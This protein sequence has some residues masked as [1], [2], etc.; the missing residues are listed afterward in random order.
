VTPD[1][2]RL[3]RALGDALSVVAKW[4]R[5]VAA[6]VGPLRPDDGSDLAADDRR[7]HPYEVSHAAWQAFLA[8]VSHLGCLRDSLLEWDGPGKITV[9]IHTHG[10]FSLVRGALENASRGLWLLEPGD[11]DERVLRRLRLEW[12]EAS[13]QAEVRG[14]VG[15]PG[16]PRANRFAELSA[17]MPPG[18]DPA[19]IRKKPGVREHRGGR[20]RPAADRL[21]DARADLE[22]VLCAGAR[23]RAGD[24]RL[25]GEG[26]RA[27]GVARGATSEGDGQ[28][29]AAGYGHADSH[30][31]GEAGPGHVPP[32]VRGHPK[33]RLTYA[34]GPPTPW[35]SC[36]R[37][38]PRLPQKRPA[39]FFERLV[40]AGRRGPREVPAGFD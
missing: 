30:R 32:A 37:A 12:V 16:R 25:H 22:D 39:S 33:Y 4:E 26:H 34:A 2:D 19:A 6:P 38:W 28:R 5:Q 7:I 15:Q 40:F 8:A 31:D 18:I 1:E 11:G 3:L 23:G 36:S 14:I 17:L 13:A 27:R 20:G 10:Q 35:L 9:R 29:A 21:R 24:G